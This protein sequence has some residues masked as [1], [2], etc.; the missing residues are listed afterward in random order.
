MYVGGD[1]DPATVSVC[2]AS[3]GE[4]LRNLSG[5]TDKVACVACD[6]DRIASSGRDKTIRVW[7]RASGECL[8]SIPSG[9]EVVYGLAMRGSLL[10][11]GE[12]LA[13]RSTDRAKAKLWQLDEAGTSTS[14][15]AT[16]AE[17]TGSIRS[18]ALSERMAL[19]AGQDSSVRV[20]D[21]EDADLDEGALT[22]SVATLEHPNGFGCGSVSIDGDM[23]VTGCADGRVRLWTLS[24]FR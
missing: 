19:T 21:H 4:V 22:A 11:S 14:L 13:P 8:V 24:N 18:V 16:F 23:I 20:F 5:H 15:L 10:L 12:G 7:S 9:D 6:G 2:S 3:S 17:H 1:G